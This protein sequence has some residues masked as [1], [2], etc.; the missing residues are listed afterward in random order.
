VITPDVA[1]QAAMGRITL[2]DMTQGTLNPATPELEHVPERSERSTADTSGRR[3]LWLTLLSVLTP[4][5]AH[6]HAGRR[7]TATVLTAFGGLIWVSV[8]FAVFNLGREHVVAAA[9]RPAVL[10]FV[11]ATALVVIPAWV[12]LVVTSYNAVRAKGMSRR[13]AR[14]ARVAVLGLCAAVATPPAL[15]AHYAYSQ[16]D[17]ITTVFADGGGRSS[18]P[19]A[20]ANTDDPQQA[21]K[22]LPGA[23]R[24]NVLLLGSDAGEGRVGTRPD[25][26]VLASVDQDTGR[27]VLLSMPRNLQNAPMPEGPAKAKYPEGYPDLLNSVYAEGTRHHLHLAPGSANPGADLL[28]GAVSQILGMPVHHFAQVDMQGFRDLV[29][30]MGGVDVNVAHRMPMGETGQFFQPGPQ[31]LDGAQA[32]WYARSRTGAS[33]YDR[34]ERQRCML[35]TLAEQAD[36]MTVLNHYHKMAAAAKDNF[37][38][39]IPADMLQDLVKL[40]EKIEPAGSIQ[41]MPPLIEP[42]NPDFNRIRAI[43]KDTIDQSEAGEEP[44]A[45]AVQHNSRVAAAC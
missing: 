37:R 32:L 43:A 9:V 2:A 18:A 24:L 42:S 36:P 28:K 11:G 10:L 3:A 44:K 19:A 38:T 27:T 21:G 22:P 17:L 25:T 41:F 29:D 13:R 20:A 7:R 16:Y 6:W 33:D 5:V 39:D 26:M 31:H 30:A 15:V 4:G 35:S 8:A 1:L 14:T 12:V 34:M 45:T 40:A 23:D